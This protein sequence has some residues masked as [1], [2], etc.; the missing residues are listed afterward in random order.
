MSNLFGPDMLQ[1]K[2]LM[3]RDTN[4]ARI[5]TRSSNIIIELLVL[6]TTLGR[7][8]AVIKAVKGLPI[9]SKAENA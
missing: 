8:N 1:V 6:Y 5:N 7:D 3:S 2:P 9:P 4:S